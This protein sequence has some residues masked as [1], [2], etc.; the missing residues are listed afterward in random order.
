M[1]KIL[2]A[3]D[4]ASLAQGLEYNLSEEGYTV[5]IARDGNEA[6]ERYNESNFDLIILDIM[7]PYR[8]GFE[9]AKEIRKITPL[10][11]ILMLTARSGVNDRVHGLE[12]GADDYLTKPFHLEELLARV[13]NMLKRKK[14]YREIT[15]EQ[16]IFR[17]GENE[18][19]FTDLSAKTSSAEFQ[20]T[21]RE[22]MVMRYLIDRKDAIVTRKELLENV[23]HIS[24]E[25]ETRTVDN[26]IARLR[27]YFEPDPKFP[28]FIISVRSAGYMFTAAG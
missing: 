20:L 19:N 23:W 11:P 5:V 8:N 9:I 18:I 22:A 17:F 24:S 21:N 7:L 4:E 10:M 13:R 16:P 6:L 26:F 27:K 14:W 3:E 15:A 25:I 12:I 2:I 1:C 28:H